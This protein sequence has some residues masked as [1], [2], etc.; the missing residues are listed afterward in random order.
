MCV[1]FLN[2]DI[3]R[4]ISDIMDLSFCRTEI[5]LLV[6]YNIKT[7]LFPIGENVGGTLFVFNVFTKILQ[8]NVAKMLLLLLSSFEKQ[9][10]PHGS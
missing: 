5:S 7:M 10:H 9:D 3:A 8:K 6:L 4:Q 2:T 1:F